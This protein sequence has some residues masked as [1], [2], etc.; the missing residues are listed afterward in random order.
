MNEHP[1]EA[2]IAIAVLSGRCAYCGSQLN[3]QYVTN[4]DVAYTWISKHNS[5]PEMH[6]VGC[7]KMAE[8]IPGY[9]LGTPRVPL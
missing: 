8:I 2:E 6:I 4:S 5:G 1:D 7:P 9:P 3:E